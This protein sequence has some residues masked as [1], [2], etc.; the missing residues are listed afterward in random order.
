MDT[1]NRK[2]NII[3]EYQKPNG[4]WV[5]GD[6]D[7]TL[8]VGSPHD[9]A[10]F[11]IDSLREWLNN[12]TGTVG[13]FMVTFLTEKINRPNIFA[14]K[15]ESNRRSVG[16]HPDAIKRLDHLLM[17]HPDYAGTGIGR[18]EFICDMVDAEFARIGDEI[19]WNDDIYHHMKK[20]I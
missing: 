6:T 13:R 19:D 18:S 12:A 20:L 9:G 7:L 4:T 5:G 15:N 8:R 17:T 16:L 10:V 14:T 3:N 1:D 2:I 11:A